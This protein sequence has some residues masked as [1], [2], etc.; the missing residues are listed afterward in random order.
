MIVDHFVTQLKE[1]GSGIARINGPLHFYQADHWHPIESDLLE[2]RL[3]EFSQRRGHRIS[4]SR[5]FRFRLDLRSQLESHCEPLQPSPGSVA[6]NF[7]NGTLRVLEGKPTLT[8]HRIDDGFTY[9]LPFKY[10]PA[11]RCPL[12]NQ[13]L[14]RVL[15]DKKCRQVVL[16]FL[17]WIFLR[18][19]KLEKMLVL[20][21]SGYNGKSVFFDVT[22]ALLGEANVSSLSLSSLKTPEKRLPL[23]GQLLNYG[24][25]I[26][27][28]LSPDI[29]KLASSGEPL[30]FRRLYGDLFT[31][32]DY[33]R[34]AFNTNTLPT[35][36]EITE[37]FFRRFLIISFEQTIRDE[38]KDPEL[39]SKIIAAEL[40]G[41]MNL[42]ME[43]IERVRQQRKFSP[44]AKSDACLAEYRH[45]SDT[46]AQF[47]EDDEWYAHTTERTSK[48]ELY[49]AYTDYC[50]ESGFQALAKKNF[51]ARL[52]TEHRIG[53]AKSGGVRYWLIQQEEKV[54]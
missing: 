15:P 49:Q 9:V 40:P 1:R 6:I 37:G 5:H 32:A 13:Y 17:G 20:H 42:V 43:G 39:A 35:E 19:L 8:E 45:E 25:E 46:V 23:L 38:E 14:E 33:A 11:A 34:L 54:S 36:T 29:I 16:E 18:D 7:R 50:R 51:A 52:K 48:A 28:N 4:D 26:G 47:L 24:S 27:G 2:Q 30:E 41:I 12:F 22:R 10:D 21:G 53:E 44:C 31:S 3:G